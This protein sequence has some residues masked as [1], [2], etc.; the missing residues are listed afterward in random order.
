MKAPLNISIKPVSDGTSGR[1]INTGTLA[2]YDV[3]GS[4]RPKSYA[5]TDSSI[6]VSLPASEE[7]N[8]WHWKQFAQ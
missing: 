2:G 7:P 1:I 3:A 5:A 6:S 8:N 4:A